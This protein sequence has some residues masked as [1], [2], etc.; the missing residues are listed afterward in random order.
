MGWTCQQ[1][2]GRPI[3]WYVA[4]TYCDGHLK[5]IDRLVPLGLSFCGLVSER[6]SELK[7]LCGRARGGKPTGGCKPKSRTHG[8]V[9]DAFETVTLV[10]I[11]VVGTTMVSDGEGHIHSS[12]RRRME[13]PMVTRATLAAVILFLLAST[14]GML[15]PYPRHAD[16]FCRW[17]Y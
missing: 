11:H 2:A 15:I 17:F 1:P 12:S 14:S 5:I 10:R 9:V 3:Y 6:D 13:P 7:V 8:S 4:Y 16:K